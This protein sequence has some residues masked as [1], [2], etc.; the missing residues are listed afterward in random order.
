M[1]SI[2]SALLIFAGLGVVLFSMFFSNKNPLA[3]NIADQ[4]KATFAPHPTITPCPNGAGPIF[5]GNAPANYDP[6]NP[7]KPKP[8]SAEELAKREK[9]RAEWEEEKKKILTANYPLKNETQIDIDGDGKKDKILYRVQPWESDFEGLVEITN[10]KGKIIWEHEF[11]MSSDDLYKFLTEV[12][13]Y[14]SVT[15]WVNSVFNKKKNYSFRV[16]NVKIKESEID[17][18]QLTHAAKVFKFSAEKVKAEILAQKTNRVF[19]YRAE[20][21]EDLMKIVYVPSIKRFVC[22]SRGY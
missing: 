10:A 1:K 8:L 11:F 14:G 4:S 6:C 2:I 18:E 17:S 16:G 5:V 7:P 19:A 20:W 9:Q 12:L 3:I 21:R 15:D 22:F 13:Y